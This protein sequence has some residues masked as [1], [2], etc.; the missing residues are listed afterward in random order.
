MIDQRIY[1]FSALD[2]L[3]YKA[4]F[5]GMKLAGVILISIGFFL[6]M[7]PNDWPEYITKS[8]RWDWSILFEFVIS[9]FLITFHE[10]G[11]R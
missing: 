11:L 5:A 2:I 7:F 3:L 1:S 10:N 6:V 4:N 8:L 9:S